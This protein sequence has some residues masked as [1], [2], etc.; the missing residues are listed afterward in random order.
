MIR[1]LNVINFAPSYEYS[2]YTHG[3]IAAFIK[4]S[5][6]SQCILIVISRIVYMKKILRSHDKLHCTQY[7]ATR[8]KN[9]NIWIKNDQVN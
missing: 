3:K 5:K 7:P 2:T 1:K 9:H 8:S 6:I 4:Q